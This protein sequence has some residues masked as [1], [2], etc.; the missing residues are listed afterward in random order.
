M[1]LEFY[2]CGAFHLIA[3]TRSRGIWCD[4]VIELSIEKLNRRA[5]RIAGAAFGPNELT[6]FEIEFHYAVRRGRN[7]LRTI[8]R[9][10]FAGPDGEIRQP[11]EKDAPRIVANRPR[12]DHEWAV[13]VE[14]TPLEA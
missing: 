8:I 9:F 2:L 3:F 12:R 1:W 7:P 13:A 11:K 14:L 10:G 6:A 5:F 4:G